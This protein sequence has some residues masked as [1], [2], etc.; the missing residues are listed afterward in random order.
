[1]Q[2]S[3]ATLILIVATVA[4]ASVV[5]SYAVSVVQTTLQTTDIPQLDNLKQIQNSILNQTDVLI[6]QYNQTLSQ[7]P[8]IIASPT[9][10]NLP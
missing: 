5:V 1:M 3:L 10:D 4:L 6:K 2:S 9:P 7:S 8:Q